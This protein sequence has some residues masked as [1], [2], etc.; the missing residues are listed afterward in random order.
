MPPVIGPQW[1]IIVDYIAGGRLRNVTARSTHSIKSPT[2]RPRSEKSGAASDNYFFLDDIPGGC[3]RRICPWEHTKKTTAAPA[4]GAAAREVDVP[5]T[6]VREA[7]TAGVLLVAI[8]A[9]ATTGAAAIASPTVGTTAEAAIA[10][11][12]IAGPVIAAGAAPRDTSSATRQ[13][14][15][16]SARSAP[17]R[18]GMR[19]R[20]GRG[21]RPTCR[22]VWLRVWTRAVQ[23]CS[24]YDTPRI[25]NQPVQHSAKLQ[26]GVSSSCKDMTA[27]LNACSIHSRHCPFRE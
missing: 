8:Q 4:T 17:L 12:V 23:H 16:R 7:E 25:L 13:G 10:G 1:M 2:K 24:N 21:R 18:W 9:G 15:P 26:T 6:T 5:G 19:R 22:K 20:G 14:Q 27:G 3:P 11:P